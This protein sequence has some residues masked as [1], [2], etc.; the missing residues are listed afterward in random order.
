MSVGLLLAVALAALELVPLIKSLALLLMAMVG[1]KIV[2]ASELRRRFPFGL[3][4]IIASALTLS[5]ALTNTGLVTLLAD[6]LHDAVAGRGPLI[7]LAGVYL[8]T[9]VMTEVMT[10]NAAAALAFPVAYGLAVS[11]GL[12]P[13]PFALA[14]AFGASASFLTPYG[15]TTNLMVQN[16]GSYAFADYLRFGLP[17]TLAYSSTVLL[18]LPVFFPLQPA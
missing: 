6:G 15:Y 12:D 14:V 3:W 4:L 8:G 13:T 10:N 11:Y 17:V 9:L 2:R 1:L 5:Q 7:A 18:L 16:L